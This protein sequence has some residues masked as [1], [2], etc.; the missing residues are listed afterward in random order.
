[1]TGNVVYRDKLYRGLGFD[2]RVFQAQSEGDK[3]GTMDLALRGLGASALLSGIRASQTPNRQSKEY[4]Q[5][6]PRN[7]IVEI[8]PLLD[9]PD[10]KVSHY[11]SQYPKHLRHPD[12]GKKST[13]GALVL[14]QTEC[15]LWL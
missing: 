14:K 3:V 6:N 5:L 13:G 8:N 11:L 10:S 1:M 7:K 2:L 9:W 12:E 15:G 4:I